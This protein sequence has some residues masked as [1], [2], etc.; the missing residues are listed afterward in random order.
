MHWYMHHQNMICDMDRCIS[1]TGIL[2]S[3]PSR[4]S[5]YLFSL[6]YIYCVNIIAD[7]N[8]ATCIL[9]SAAV[10]Q[11]VHS[12]TITSFAPPQAPQKLRVSLPL[13]YIIVFWPFDNF[14]N[15]ISWI[16]Y[17]WIS[18]E[19]SVSQ[20]MWLTSVV[21]TTRIYVFGKKMKKLMKSIDDS[22]E[23]TQKTNE[24]EQIHNTPEKNELC[25]YNSGRDWKEGKIA[26]E[27]ETQT[28]VLQV[29]FKGIQLICINIIYSPRSSVHNGH[30]IHTTD[31]LFF[32]SSLCCRTAILSSQW[33][34][35]ITTWWFRTHKD[36]WIYLERHETTAPF[37]P[38]SNFVFTPSCTEIFEIF[39]AGRLLVYLKI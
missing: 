37:C 36:G 18:W 17:S 7:V 32:F 10:Q 39:L 14:P 31:F 35:A 16:S 19:G 5:L 20:E 30:H 28:V 23:Y 29:I 9:Y 13:F 25:R 1:H 4:A 15:G 12:V 22:F 26:F 2:H 38:L 33:S 24:F 3:K 11:L 34:F 6:L 27:E 21:Y 8:G